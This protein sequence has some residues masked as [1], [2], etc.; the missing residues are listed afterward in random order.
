MDLGFRAICRKVDINGDHQQAKRWYRSG[1]LFETFSHAD[2]ICHMS[3][4]AVMLRQGSQLDLS[5]TGTW[6]DKMQR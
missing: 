5:H 6:V 4:R 2:A 1:A 3:P